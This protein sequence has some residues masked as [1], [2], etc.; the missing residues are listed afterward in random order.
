MNELATNGYAIIMVSSE[1]P[2][3]LGMADRVVVM[4]NGRVSGIMDN[5]ELTQ[6]MILE[7]SLKSAEGGEA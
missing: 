4:R 7:H 3:V 6:E 1:M 5:K 2:E